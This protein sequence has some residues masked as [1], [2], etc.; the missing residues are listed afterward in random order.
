M[1]ILETIKMQ[2]EVLYDEYNSLISSATL[3][4]GDNSPKIKFQLENNR[5]EVAVFDA[6]GEEEVLLTLKKKEVLQLLKLIGDISKPLKIE[7]EPVT[8]EPPTEEEE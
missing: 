5:L 1:L 2:T 7:D 6:L 4:E 8:S 3:V